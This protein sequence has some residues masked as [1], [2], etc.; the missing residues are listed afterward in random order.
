MSA[1]HC[2]GTYCCRGAD[3][4]RWLELIRQW[5]ALNLPCFIRAAEMKDRNEGMLAICVT[6]RDD[7]D[8]PL[9]DMAV[10]YAMGH[11]SYYSVFNQAELRL[12]AQARRDRRQH[13]KRKQERL[14]AR[15]VFGK[16]QFGC[17]YEILNIIAQYAASSRP[18][19]DELVLGY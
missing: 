5:A 13:R 9:I 1:A 10:T 19:L 2:G 16:N 15:A 12:A 14:L 18:N 3:M 6:P 17:E 7:S 11:D 4:V 8:L